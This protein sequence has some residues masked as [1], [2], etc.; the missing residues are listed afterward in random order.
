[1][2]KR[3]ALVL[4][5]LLAL[6]LST[7]VGEAQ[8]QNP[9][10]SNDP[11]DFTISKPFFENLLQQKTFLPSY[12]IRMDHRSDI[13]SLGDDCEVHLAGFLQEPFV[14]GEPPAVVVEP[15]NLCKFMPNADSPTTASTK[16]TWRTRLD[17]QVLKRDCTVVGFPRIYTEH[18]TGGSAGGSNPNHVFEIHPATSIACQG[19]TTLTFVKNLRAFTGLRHIQASSAHNCL[20]N[21]KLWVRFHNEANSNHYEFFQRRPS[22]CGN[23]VIVEVTS[24]P[25]EWIRIAS[26]GGGHTAIARVLANGQ[27]TLTLKLFAL[28][29][30]EANA[31]LARVKDG[32]PSLDDPRLVHGVL[33]YDYSQIFQTIGTAGGQLGTPTDW[34]EVKFPLALVLLGGTTV[35]PWE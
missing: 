5:S 4:S 25:Q 21:F 31:W 35:V 3:G 6:S 11:P 12:R 34:T 17:N 23:F 7:I 15:P 14:F 2:R 32:K 19:S 16:A 27:D 24:L 9:P 29:G 33:T 20:T 28:E 8:N 1:M 22:N 26:G 18:A 30:S 13:H 10:G